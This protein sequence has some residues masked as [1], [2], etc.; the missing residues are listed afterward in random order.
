[1]MKNK[2]IIATNK[3]NNIPKEEVKKRRSMGKDKKN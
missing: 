2:K 3:T 1:M